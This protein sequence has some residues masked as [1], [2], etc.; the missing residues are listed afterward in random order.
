MQFSAVPVSCQMLIFYL[1]DMKRR[2]DNIRGMSACCKSDPN[3]FDKLSKEFT[4]TNFQVK[5]QNMVAHPESNDA[6]YVLSK[7]LHLF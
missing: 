4:P 2:H 6:T 7:L 5:I 1:F 3:A